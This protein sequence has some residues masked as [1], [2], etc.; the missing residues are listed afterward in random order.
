MASSLNFP[1]ITR[2]ITYQQYDYNVY[3]VGKPYVNEMLNI[4]IVPLVASRTNN[5]GETISRNFLNVYTFTS[6]VVSFLQQ[7][8]IAEDRT[9]N[10]VS[11]NK[12]ITIDDQGRIIVVANTLS[13]SFVSKI[14]IYT[15]T[16]TS[17]S[18][19]PNEK[20]IEDLQ[21]GDVKF[22]G[23][24]V[25]LD[26][27]YL[28]GINTASSQITVFVN[29]L[30]SYTTETILPPIIV[31][32]PLLTFSE[33]E[34]SVVSLVK[35]NGD[36]YINYYNEN[37]IENILIFKRNGTGY[38][39]AITKQIQHD[40][41]Q[42]VY[43]MLLSTNDT[44]VFYNNYTNELVEN[45]VNTGYQTRIALFNESNT[46]LFVYGYSISPTGNKVS[47]HYYSASGSYLST[48]IKQNNVWTLSNT[49]PTQSQLNNYPNNFSK[50][51]N[52]YIHVTTSDDYVTPY[53]TKL[54]NLS[55]IQEQQ[56]I[57]PLDESK[58]YFAGDLAGTLSVDSAYR[59]YRTATIYTF[60]NPIA[61]GR[62]PP[63]FY[64]KFW[65]SRN[66]I[67]SA[68]DVSLN[69][70]VTADQAVASLYSTIDAT[71]SYQNLFKFNDIS[72]ISIVSS[73]GTGVNNRFK[74]MKW[75]HNSV[76]TNVTLP[77]FFSNAAA[78]TISTITNPQSQ[79][80]PAEI[81]VNIDVSGI[82][83]YSTNDGTVKLPFNLNATPTSRTY[84]IT[85][86]PGKIDVINDTGSQPTA[87][88]QQSST[89][90]SINTPSYLN[91]SGQLACAS[92]LT[93]I[94][95]E[96]SELNTILYDLMRTHKASGGSAINTLAAARNLIDNMSGIVSTVASVPLQFYVAVRLFNP[97]NTNDNK[98]EAISAVGAGVSSTSIT[99]TT[100]LINN[101]TLPTKALLTN[102]N[103]DSTTNFPAN[104]ISKNPASSQQ[105]PGVLA[106]R[107]LN[108][109]IVFKDPA[110][111]QS[112]NISV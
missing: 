111:V 24:Q 7:I 107:N 112:A 2:D 9:I 86:T 102:S 110:D 14:L 55:A 37:N 87:T 20:A 40:N 27:G 46:I 69:G 56:T 100:Q 70:T 4:I 68:I 95:I 44:G 64:V 17:W 103:S 28:C 78:L 94:N 51:G 10:V 32:M 42:F 89:Q 109:W 62:G 99:G 31:Q 90:I 73:G 85:P 41:V 25:T 5:T 19:I 50:S 79:N 53:S 45:Y 81:N 80:S 76:N 72:G 16:G 108:I 36:V 77:D 93:R 61:A 97:D 59:E 57:I 15:R 63:E 26:S 60:S 84:T 48:Y 96:D 11:G 43:R 23:H 91:E 12:N 67:K 104:N 101:Q 74:E 71:P 82:T 39:Q 66:I 22:E 88:Q 33:Y 8:A 105:T 6:S 83:T 54:Y 38:N 18:A 1:S 106:S 35:S 92:T 21:N 98:Q 13:Q 3:N 29:T 47:I 34:L 75:N 52:F 30:T 65:T 58:S 49:L